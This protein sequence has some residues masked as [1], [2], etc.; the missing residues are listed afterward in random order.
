MKEGQEKDNTELKEAVME[1]ERDA[2]QLMGEIVIYADSKNPV[3]CPVL[4]QPPLSYE[5]HF[6]LY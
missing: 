5:S 4:P 2:W 3:L 6:L 1:G